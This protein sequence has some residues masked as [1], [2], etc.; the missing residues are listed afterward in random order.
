[1]V[2]RKRP[3]A[4]TPSGST[5]TTSWMLGMVEQEAVDRAVIAVGE[6]G[7]EA[8]DIEPLRAGLAL[9]QAAEEADL[10]I[11]G[12]QVD[13]LIVQAFVDQIAVEMLE[14]ADR[15]L[16]LLHLQS[17]GQS[18]DLGLERGDAI[19]VRHDVPLRLRRPLANG[20]CLGQQFVLNT[21]K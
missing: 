20:S 5:S 9:E 4:V 19:L 12:E 7:L 14:L 2:Q 21:Y 3:S 11:L 13:D 16:V 17:A 1:M 18:R 6:G 15:L 8:V 10:A